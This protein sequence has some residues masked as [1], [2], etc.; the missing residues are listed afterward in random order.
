MSPLFLLFGI[1]PNESIVDFLLIPIVFYVV[2]AAAQLDLD[3]L[4]RDGWLFETAQEVGGVESWYTFYTYYGGYRLSV[5]C[6]GVDSCM[7]NC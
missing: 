5:R 2:V 4:R 1:P 3:V 6:C 7:A